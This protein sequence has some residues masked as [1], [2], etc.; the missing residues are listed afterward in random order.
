MEGGKQI[1]GGRSTHVIH[2]IKNY[3]GVVF[4]NAA[5]CQY[6]KNNTEI[7]KLEDC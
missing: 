5:R 4:I 6:L 7:V 1:R 3:S 2:T